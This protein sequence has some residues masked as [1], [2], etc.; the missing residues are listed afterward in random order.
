[1]FQQLTYRL[2][3]FRR[4]HKYIFINSIFLLV[5]I[6]FLIYSYWSNLPAEDNSAII[7]EK[8]TYHRSLWESITMALFPPKTKPFEE[9][10]PQVNPNNNQEVGVESGASEISQHKQQ[11][12]QQQHAK[13]PTTKTLMKSL[14]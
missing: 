7:N 14:V 3:L 11:Q 5:I 12:Q 8:G 1:M 2:R 9:K 4:R 13:E 10:K 6:I